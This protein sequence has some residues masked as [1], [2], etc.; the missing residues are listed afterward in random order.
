MDTTGNTKTKDISQYLH[1]YLGC[2]CLIG[3][4]KNVHFIEMVSPMY[5][6]TGTNKISIQ[7]WYK[8]SAC[9]PVLR[10]LSDM[11]EEERTELICTDID[12]YKPLKIKLKVGDYYPE[13]K[14]FIYLLS[15]HFDLFGLIESGLA[16]DKTTLK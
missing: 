7:M 5:V 9:K 2:Q 4:S 6:C 12:E 1:L 15:K 13:S 16:I 11:T 8:K 3:D 10:P 14:R